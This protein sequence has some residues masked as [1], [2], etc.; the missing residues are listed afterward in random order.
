MARSF[1]FYDRHGQVV[2]LQAGPT[3]PIEGRAIAPQLSEIRAWLRDSTSRRT[4]LQMGWPPCEKTPTNHELTHI[5]ERLARDL[6][7]GVLRAFRMDS[8]FVPM[9]ARDLDEA[10]VQAPRVK[11][12]EPEELFNPRWSKPRVPV[13]TEVE[14]IVSYSDI[15][16]P[17]RANIL[18]SEVDSGGREQV[19]KIPTTIPVGS[20]SHSVRWRRD[21]EAAQADLQEDEDAG[22]GGPLEYRFKVDSE[23]P[24]CENESGPLWLTNTVEVELLKERDGKTV[25][26]HRVVVLTD[27]VGE[28]QRKASRNGTVTFENVLVGPMEIRFAEP[29]FSKLTWSSSPVPVGAPVEAVF[30]YED[31]FDG[32]EAVVVVYETNRDGTSKEIDRLDVRLAADTGQASVSFTRTEEEAQDD[33]AEDEAEG[34]SGP[35]EYRYRVHAE[36]ERSKLSDPLWLTQAVSIDLEETSEGK[37]LPTEMMVV[38]VAADGTEHRAPVANGGA[39][40]DEVVC[41]PMIV[42]VLPQMRGTAS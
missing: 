28:E 21:P 29:S 2:V 25:E 35:L 11:T 15:K 6:E 40:F 31:A 27:A 30:R 34:D 23:D 41:G 3:A 1:R 16:A 39:K 22:E 18:I 13:G 12:K 38:L 8:R 36:G 7:R 17:V 5:A 42:R 24:K 33:I 14:A 32:M 4:L 10:A 9:K 20:G 26:H 19:T 37:R